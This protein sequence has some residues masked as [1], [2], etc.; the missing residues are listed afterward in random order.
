VLISVIYYLIIDVV[1]GIQLTVLEEEP[2]IRSSRP[3]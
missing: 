3:R 2:A 1:G